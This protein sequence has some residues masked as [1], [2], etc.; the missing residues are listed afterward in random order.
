MAWARRILRVNLTKGTCSEEPLNMDWAMKYIGQR[1]LATKYLAEE[2]DAKID[3][4]SPDNKIPR[5]E[6]QAIEYLTGLGKLYPSYIPNAKVFYCPSLKT[7]DSIN[8]QYLSLIH[9]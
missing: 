9:I 1:G 8:I 6:T 2:V 3:A 5:N 7:K 4:L